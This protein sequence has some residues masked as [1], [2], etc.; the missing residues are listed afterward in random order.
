M[1]MPD[2]W[3][4]NPRPDPLV[5]KA[6]HN[7]QHPVAEGQV[8]ALAIVTI[9]PMLNIETAVAGDID[10]VRK[11]ILAAGLIELAHKILSK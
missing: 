10:P 4:R 9:D 5:V 2:K 1:G 8:R 6:A 7:L 11:R 3:A